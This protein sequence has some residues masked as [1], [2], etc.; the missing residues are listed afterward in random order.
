M[1]SRAICVFVLLFTLVSCTNTY[2]VR[3]DDLLHAGDVVEAR[4]QDGSRTW[5][6]TDSIVKQEANPDE[7][8]IEVEAMDRRSSW[9][10]TGAAAAAIGTAIALGGAAM[11]RS[12]GRMDPPPHTDRFSRAMSGG[13][14]FLFGTMGTAAGLGL[15]V[16]GAASGGPER[17]AP[18]E[19]ALPPS[20]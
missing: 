3:R 4:R 17:P 5:L 9:L 7:E 14:F 19:Q 6:D 2:H 13:L 16:A 1:R 20:R 12:A 15:M 8:R 10:L 11:Y 18:A